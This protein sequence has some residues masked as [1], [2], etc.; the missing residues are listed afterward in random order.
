L[1]APER[2]DGVPLAPPVYAP[3]I[4]LEEVMP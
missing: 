2:S 1:P 4:P 3:G